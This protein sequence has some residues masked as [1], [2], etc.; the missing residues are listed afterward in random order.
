MEIAPGGSPSPRPAVPPDR[1]PRFPLGEL[2]LAL[3]K[4][5]LADI[6]LVVLFWSLPRLCLEGSYFLSFKGPGSGNR[7]GW[8]P[9]SPPRGSPRT[10]SAVPLG[11]LSLA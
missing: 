11:E 8:F 1:A 6:I 10:R 5:R 2:S 4:L 7:P 9:R 3:A